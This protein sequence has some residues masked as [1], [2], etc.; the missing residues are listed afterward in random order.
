MDAISSENI[1]NLVAS[2]VR[3]LDTDYV[4]IREDTG[5]ALLRDIDLFSQVDYYQSLVPGVVIMAIFLGTLT[6]GA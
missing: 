5:E 3:S 6:T 2:T 4:A 1:R